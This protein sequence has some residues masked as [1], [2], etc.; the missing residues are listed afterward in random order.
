M[1][2]TETLKL[3]ITADSGAAVAGIQKVG[4]ETQKTL[5][6]SE[7]SLASFGKGLSKV[8]VGMIGVGAVLLAGLGKAA[9]AS[10][11]ANLST[12]KLQNSLSAN[13][14]LAG[15]SAKGFIDLAQAIQGKTAADGDDIVAGE[16]VLAQGRLSAK[17][18]KE[19][20][21]LVVDLA[22][23]KG[24]DEVQ[25]FTLASKA[26]LGNAGALKRA[27]IA[28]DEVKFK[29]DAFKGTVDALRTSVGGYAEAEGKTF[30]GSLLRL[31]N[32]FHDL[33]EGVGKGAVQA[34]TSLFNVVGGGLHK[35]ESISPGA[36]DAIG[37]IGAFGAMGLV[38]AGGVATL[39]GKLIAAK[40][41]FSEM[42]VASQTAVVGL[43]AAA[44]A[45]AGI[46]AVASLRA[47]RAKSWVDQMIGD[48][49]PTKLAQ[50]QDAI[51]RAKQQL[52]DLGGEQNKKG[53]LFSIGGAD[54]FATPGDAEHHAKI[55]ATQKEIASLEAQEKSLKNTNDDAAASFAGATNA[56]GDMGDTTKATIQQLKDYTDTLHSELDPQFGM[57]D[58]LQA[59]ADAQAKVTEA[60]I[61]YM[62]AVKAHGAHS[63]EATAAEEALT[64]AR[65]ASGKSA[66]DVTEATNKLNAAVAANPALLDD[67]KAQL[68]VWAKQGL[69]SQ[70]T[71]A[72]LAAQLDRTA[73]KAVALGRTDPSVNVKSTGTK[74]TNAALAG[75]T[76]MVYGVPTKRIVAVGAAGINAARVQL[77]R[78]KD[79]V[80]NVPGSKTVTIHFAATGAA[81]VSIAE[82]KLLGPG[83][84][85]GGPTEAGVVYP[86]GEH[87]PELF[88]ADVP[89]HII[90]TDRMSMLSGARP[91]TLAASSQL[92]GQVI[93]YNTTNVHVD[94]IVADDPKRLFAQLQQH[95]KNTGPLRIKVRGGL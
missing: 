77:Q 2:V 45:M 8:G 76:R 40:A 75:T 38:A 47:G 69:I 34:F 73:M 87:G 12:V 85:G 35:I 56:M 67:S 22:R 60:E 88:V 62:K 51:T 42:S 44:A 70:A 19:L 71:A 89:G 1:G 28:V 78:V 31:R 20:T 49:D 27:G 46:V 81:A 83:H 18:I 92:G 79:A 93:T 9:K 57:I 37:K 26:T 10:E 41:A 36:Q 94:K 39:V 66:L 3:L 61:N 21:P 4:N 52:A 14:R 90:P 58:A 86:V 68:M 6:K 48:F 25:A 15:T 55:R 84:A 74:E 33:E 95:M 16:A 80:D 24:L 7:S 54:I 50:V 91:M 5:T 13:P 65:L 64:A 72:S 43:G 17:Q 23:K 30:S 11:E 63:K 82:A 29:S 59:N 53:R 32:Q